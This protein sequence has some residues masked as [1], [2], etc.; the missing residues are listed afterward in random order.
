MRCIHETLNGVK[1]IEPTVFGDERGYFYEAFNQNSLSQFGING[2]FVQDNQSQSRRGILRGLHY[3]IHQQQD[4]LVRCLSG[5]IYDVSVDLRIG[6]PTC[7][8]WYGTLLNSVN[9]HMVW[10]PKG[11]A[12][13]YLVLSETAEV[14]YKVTNYWAKDQE[15]G[16]CWND[17]EIGINWPALPDAY[18]LN[19]RDA[20]FPR[21]T[22]IPQIDRPDF[23]L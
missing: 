2:L 8:K 11:F 16:L 15:R 13:G 5:E 9:K 22:A 21:F 17:P 10:V 20:N 12:H 1:L 3:Q 19:V 4:K 23:K 7:G 6:S 18:S 14:L